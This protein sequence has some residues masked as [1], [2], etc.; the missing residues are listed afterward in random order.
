MATWA[1]WFNFD[2]FTLL[3][4]TENIYKVIK[5]ESLGFNKNEDFYLKP[6]RNLRMAEA[7]DQAELSLAWVGKVEKLLLSSSA[8]SC[9]K[10]IKELN[11]IEDFG[12]D[13]RLFPWISFLTTLILLG[14]LLIP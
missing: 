10:Y 9:F 6:K 14:V 12:Q 8:S 11:L 4:N 3:K 13:C 1:Q 2:D 7:W 5:F